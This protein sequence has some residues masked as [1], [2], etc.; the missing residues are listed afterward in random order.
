MAI[1]AQAY[2]A[3][4]PL[5]I[6]YVSISP[7]KSGRSMSQMLIDGSSSTAARPP[8]CARR[9]RRSATVQSG[10]T[11]LSVALLLFSGLSFTRGLQRLYE[12]SF[13]LPTLGV[14]EHEVGRPVAARP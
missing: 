4:F 8:R 12:G 10:V 5:L 11:A 2:T 1:G 14:Q 9:S 6:V 7:L 13:S 3:L